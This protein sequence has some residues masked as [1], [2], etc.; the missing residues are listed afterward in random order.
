MFSVSVRG[1]WQRKGLLAA[2]TA[3]FFM[4]LTPVFGKIAL[5]TGLPPFAVAAWRTVMAA[6]IMGAWLARQGRH[7]FYIHPLGL[8]GALLAGGLN[9]LGS[10][11]FYMSLD[12]LGAALGQLLFSL[13]PLFL[14]L[15][16][17]LD[18]EPVSRLSLL[19]VA[20]AVP[21]VYLL[22][23][24][25]GVQRIS[26]LAV[27]MM[28][29]A[30]ALY[31][32]HVPV[33]RRVLYEAPA[34]T[35]TFYTLLGMSLVVVLAYV[36]VGPVLVPAAWDQWR[37]LVA[38][39]GV[40]F[41]SRLMLFAGVKR[42]GSLQTMLLTLGELGVALGFAHVWLGER[43]HPWQW[44]GVV[45]LLLILVLGYFE[46]PTLSPRSQ[47]GGWLRWLQPPRW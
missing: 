16:V 14:L 42:L 37:A 4:G 12:D 8:M 29:T 35:V 39:A 40:T 33:N 3:A 20:L 28:L 1:S 15:W 43:L 34:P 19:R 45:G 9:G 18:R 23:R 46:R 10:L 27:A 36:L 11:F 30:S 21:T 24:P 2:L 26:F 41:L 38:L 22:T 32:L 31:A 25:P 47:T 44:W 5:D 13:H 7:R 6:G 17:W